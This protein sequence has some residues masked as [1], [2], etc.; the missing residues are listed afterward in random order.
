MSKVTQTEKEAIQAR[1]VALLAELKTDS[2]LE[3]V[4]GKRGAQVKTADM[5]IAAWSKEIAESP[6]SL[7]ATATFTVANLKSA[8]ARAKT[9]ASI[10]VQ[11]GIDGFKVK[12]VTVDAEGN[13]VAGADAVNVVQGITTV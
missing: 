10:L 1:M 11:N 8:V 9:Q 2:G 7:A 13:A 6:L 5:R 12:L 3:V 4:A